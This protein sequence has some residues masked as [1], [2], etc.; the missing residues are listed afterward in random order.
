MAKVRFKSDG[1]VTDMK[2]TE[3]LTL[4]NSHPEIFND[5]EI[6]DAPSQA[7]AALRGAGQGVSLGFSDELAGVAGALGNLWGKYGPGGVGDQDAQAQKQR[8]ALEKRYGKAMVDKIYAADGPKKEEPSVYSQSRDDAREED[9][10]AELL[11]PK[12][13]KGAEIAGSVIAPVPGSGAAVKAGTSL[14]KAAVKAVPKIAESALASTLVRGA[15]KGLARGALAGGEFAAGKSEANPLDNPI[16]FTGDVLRGTATG[17]AVGAPL[18]AGGEV[19]ATKLAAVLGREADKAAVGKLKS[20]NKASETIINNSK[21][22]EEQIGASARQNGLIPKNN[23]RE[24]IGDAKRQ[25]DAL[26]RSEKSTKLPREQTE[27]DVFETIK[28]LLSGKKPTKPQN[29]VTKRLPSTP[30][31]VDVLESLAGAAERSPEAAT[32][33]PKLLEADRPEGSPPVRKPQQ[34]QEEDYSFFPYGP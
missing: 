28:D 23:T 19:A 18:G 20:S 29:F 14:S 1:S 10:L 5:I 8:E 2:A 17:A 34:V 22:T 7:N 11:H 25:V 6:V 15:G 31:K 4:K 24:S 26:I 12:T 21:V 16:D 9:A 13:F 3:L 27:L 32:L 33:V 30:D